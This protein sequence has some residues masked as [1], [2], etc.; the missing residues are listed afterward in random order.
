MDALNS[1]LSKAK[2]GRRKLTDG[3]LAAVRKAKE[4][5]L[6]LEH[7]Q[8]NME[9]LV[10]ELHRRDAESPVYL[11]QIEESE[12]KTERLLQQLTAQNKLS[13]RKDKEHHEETERFEY[14]I[15]KRIEEIRRL[16]KLVYEQ[17]QQIEELRNR[18]IIST[19][20]RILKRSGKQ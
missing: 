8:A 19:A 14:Y 4:F 10:A 20:T 1:Q 13:E 6:E 15:E 7:V 5:E 18:G 12:L 2:K 11:R 16:T 17:A 3:K 9:Q